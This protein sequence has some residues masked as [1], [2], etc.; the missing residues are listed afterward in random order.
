M[1]ATP[2]DRTLLDLV[3]GAAPA[4]VDDVLALMQR[5]DDA[6]PADDGLKWFNRL[7]MM[8]TAH[9]DGAP[10][11]GGWRDAAW[12]MYL[13]VVFA[14]R[15]FDA[16]SRWLAGA[17][18]VP[19]S[20]TAL[21]ENRFAPKIERVQFA[22]AGMNAHINY[23]LPLALITAN[24]SLGQ[25][26][27]RGGPERDDFERVNDILETV[28]P[29]ALQFLAVGVLGQIAQDTGRIGRLL[30]IW[31]VRAARD[32]AWDE[33]DRT[34]ALPAPARLAALAAQDQIT[35]VLGRSLLL[36]A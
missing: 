24:Q 22:L 23:D 19:R 7:Y 17:G 10:P 4:T 29:E 33:A 6:L 15:Y 26:P 32:L 1:T 12:L 30:A 36:T 5:I 28:L 21:F 8:V 16:L 31:N 11:A 25:W 18:D 13:D 9:I 27:A 3:Q 20:W 35:G 34:H 14:A 2:A